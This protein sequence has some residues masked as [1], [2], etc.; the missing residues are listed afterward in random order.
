MTIDQDQTRTVT[1]AWVTTPLPVVPKNK[2]SWSRRIFSVVAGIL[3]GC[4]CLGG[5]AALYYKEVRR[6]RSRSPRR[7]K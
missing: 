4:I 6:R 3:V 5:T 1:H 7:P 2:L